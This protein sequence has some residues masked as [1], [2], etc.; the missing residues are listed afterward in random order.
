MDF[1]SNQ[2][3]HGK[4]ILVLGASKTLMEKASIPMTLANGDADPGLVPGL[5]SMSD[6]AAAKFVAALGRHRHSERER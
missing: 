4:T 1:I 6:H 5:A 2:Y 3:R